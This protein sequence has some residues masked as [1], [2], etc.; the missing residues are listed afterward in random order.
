MTRMASCGSMK[1]RG[2]GAK[3]RAR[4]DGKARAAPRSPR[5]APAIIVRVAGRYESHYL[6]A[7]D[8]DRPARR[9]DPPHDAAAP[10]RPAGGVVLV[11]GL[12]R[13]GRPAGHRE[14]HGAGAPT[15]VLRRT[16]PR[17]A[18]RG[19]RAGGVGRSRVEPA[20]A[21]LRHLPHP[22]LYAAPLPR[23]K[24]ES[25][26]PAAR[27]ERHA[28]PPATATLELDGWPGMAGHNWGAQHAETW[29]W[30]HGIGFDG[31]PGAWLDLAVGR[32]RIARP[33]D[34]VDRQRRAGAR[35]RAATSSAGCA[36]AARG[37]REP[38]R[39]DGPHGR[40][41]RPGHR[42]ARPER[43]LGLRRPARG[44]AP[45]LNCSIARIEVTHGGRSLAS[46]PRR[47]GRA[48]HPRPWARHPRRTLP[49]P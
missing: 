5:I 13:G 39:G 48:G 40:H 17:R 41:A 47:R 36:R 15:A 31:A 16:G 21:P 19:A 33:D 9:L 23:T 38:H 10:G 43:R 11:H 32:V 49:D 34:A 18:R 14:G 46:A 45:A 30:L 12:G 27:V 7:V 25:P 8:P 44:R 35:R 3:V 26:A 1:H 42:A 4:S 37:R 6:R 20:A 29:L 28:S 2:M 22:R 24:L